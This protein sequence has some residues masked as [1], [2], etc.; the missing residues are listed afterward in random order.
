M[1]ARARISPGATFKKYARHTAAV[2]N[3]AK[4][5]MGPIRSG[6]TRREWILK[7]YRGLGT[8][9]V[10]ACQCQVGGGVINE[11]AQHTISTVQEWVCDVG[12]TYRR[13]PSKTEAM[14][15]SATTVEKVK[16]VSAEPQRQRR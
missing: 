16:A 14:L 1:I 2:F 10:V 11:V 12:M 13:R 15:V 7:R 8:A 5:E 6:R 4:A 3:L 9:P